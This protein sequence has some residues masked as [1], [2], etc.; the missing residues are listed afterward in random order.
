MAVPVGGVYG[1]ILAI[2]KRP[3]T[4][5]PGGYWVGGAVFG[6]IWIPL[7]GYITAPLMH[8]DPVLFQLPISRFLAESVGNGVWGLGTAFLLRFPKRFV[9][10]T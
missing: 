5:F 8:T 7:V 6:L 1:A 4:R 9:P 2:I 3:L 10:L